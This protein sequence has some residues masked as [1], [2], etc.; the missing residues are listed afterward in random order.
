MILLVSLAAC[1]VAPSD[2]ASAD[3]KSKASQP[4]QLLVEDNIN[5]LNVHQQMPRLSWYANVKTQTAYQIRVAS[6]ESLLAAGKANLWDSGKVNSG[7]SVNIPYQGKKLGANQKAVWQVRVWSANRDKP[8]QWSKPQ[9]W[10]MGLINQSDWQAKW[11]QVKQPSVA[12]L[13]EARLNWIK[14]AANV[15]PAATEPATGSKLKTQ[16]GV[17]EQLKQQPTA[18]LFR[19]SFSTV[20][21]KGLVRAKLHSTA[22][23][24]YEIFING[25]KVDDRLADPGQT[26]FDKRILYNTDKVTHLL[27]GGQ[28]TIAV[29]LGSGWY[30]ENIAFSKWTNPD[31][32]QGKR[33][34][35]T[36]SFG[37]PKFI[38][39]LELTYADGSSQIVASNEQWLSHP[40]P[41]LKEG[42]FSGELYDANQTVKDWNLNTA[43]ENLAN[44]QAVEVLNEWPTKKLEPQLLP[45]IRA[46]KKLTPIKLYQPRKNVWVFDF[47]QNFTGIPT[48]NLAKLNLAQGQAVHM[49]YGEWADIDGNLSQKSG[50]G[51]PLLKQVDTYIASGQD[52]ASWSPVFTWHGF[53]YLELTGIDFKPDLDTVVGH[54]VRSDVEVV[55][56]FKSS[57]ALLNRIHDMA[58]WSYEGN[59]MSVP[60]DCPIRERAGWTGDAHAALITGNYNY[61]MQNFWQKYLGD[62]ATS[63]HIAPAVVPGKRSHGGTYDWA[64]A[65]IIIAWEHYRHHGDLQVIAEQYDSM[66]EYM[67]AAESQLTNNLLRKG[68]GDWCDPV[69]KPGMTRKRCNPEYT[70][71]TMTTSGFLAH[72]AELMAK[73][74]TL[75]NKPEKA[76]HYQAL[77]ER[78]AAQYHKEFYNPATG[79]YGSQTADA[80]A[81]RFGLAP[82]EIR[83]SVADALNKD[84][85][86][87]WHGHGSIG[88]LGQ[89]YVYRALSDYGYG[90]TAF[91]IFTAEGYPG[92]KWQF[93]KLNATTLWERK[94]VW[95][96]AKD[97][98]GRNPAGRS[99]N[100]PFHSGYDGWFYEG[101]G[102]IRPKGDTPGFQHFELAPVFVKDL[103]WV[104][105]SYKTG[106]G[107]IVSNWKR[108]GNQVE[109][110]FEVPNNSTATVS[111]PDKPTKVYS[112]GQYTLK[113]SL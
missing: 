33:K 75:L 113:V 36:L 63:S 109:W 97:P 49:R 29:H 25:Q 2:N 19:H 106:Y 112:A 51:A 15:H 83:Q 10:E 86:E 11:L 66:L 108:F 107:K 23:G 61:D 28:N 24:Y 37:Q 52:Q 32:T 70:L 81:L 58:L 104:E 82:K 90:D 42:L 85:L 12:A 46:V 72:G 47:G 38:A 17:V 92:Y 7:V 68:Y 73:M 99:L 9:F 31:A 3:T 27:S 91:G 71:P 94:G 60:M 101:L 64:V 39:Q 79:H 45:A 96:P 62:F 59:L 88:A 80:M 77:F 41:V 4:S 95:D 1:S 102:G 13:T 55:G 84:V 111:L 48:L 22:G 100:H 74:S 93:E 6:N 54:L 57:S 16:L 21:D 69:R 67:D 103:D 34:Q 26:D 110:Y 8:S 40:S 53:R 50:G 89:T 44:W 43:P 56:Q 98:E 18:S 20:Q 76:K 5:P 87:N 78:I 30:D 14:Y 65:E 35:K 105:V